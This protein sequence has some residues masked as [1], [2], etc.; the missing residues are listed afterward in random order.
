MFSVEAEFFVLDIGELAVYDLG[1]N[2][3]Q[4]GNG[5]LEDDQALAQ[6][7]AAGL[8]AGLKDAGGVEGREVKRRIEAGDQ[9]DQ[10]DAQE[11]AGQKGQEG[12]GGERISVLGE[13]VEPGHCRWGQEGGGEEGE[14][15]EEKRFAQELADQLAAVCAKDFAHSHFPSA[16]NRAGCGQVDEVDAGDEQDEQGHGGEDIEVADV[17]FAADVAVVPETIL[18]TGIVDL[19]VEVPAEEGL[20]AIG[21]HV[22][23]FFTHMALD[24]CGQFGFD[25]PE[26]CAFF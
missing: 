10:A 16:A 25:R 26:V 20:E 4:D 17:A 21:E 5:K 14:E 11:E 9:A 13:V 3:E 18:G 1:G 19:A 15:G 8:G 2:D 23:D 6:P 22:A 7:S 24:E 12:V